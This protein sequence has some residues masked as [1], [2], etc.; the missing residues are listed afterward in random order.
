M[1]KFLMMILCLGMCF[2][3][4]S[5][6][7][8]T[9]GSSSNMSES[10]GIVDDPSELPDESMDN[11]S[12]DSSDNSTPDDSGV[13]DDSTGGSSDDSTGGSSDDSTE[14]DS[15]DDSPS[16]SSDDSSDDSSGDSSSATPP[17]INEDNEMPLVPI[18]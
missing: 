4:A 12:G 9:S 7:L 13:T 3:V 11:E 18:G 5:C 17:I 6:S 15:S 1:K 10:S 16:D 2:T 8:G 14:D